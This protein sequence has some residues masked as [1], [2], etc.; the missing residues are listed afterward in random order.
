VHQL[1]GRLKQNN[2]TLKHGL[3]GN[4][5]WEW[6]QKGM[7]DGKVE[8][9]N[10]TIVLYNADLTQKKWWDLIDAYPIKWTGPTFASDKH[11]ITV[12]SLELVH[13]GIK[14]N[15]WAKV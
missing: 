4:E 14:M 10:V 3:A 6:F 15:D 9:L 8:R 13:H 2:V 11:D 5:L 1:P 7:Y 12:E